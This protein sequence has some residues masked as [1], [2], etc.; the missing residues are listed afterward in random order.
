MEHEIDG[1]GIGLTLSK[2]LDEGMNG[3]IGFDRAPQQGTIFWVRLPRAETVDIEPSAEIDP[4][5]AS[6]DISCTVLYIEDNPASRELINMA[7]SEHP[8]LHLSMAGTGEQGIDIAKKT[9]PDLIL[10]DI[11]LPG[12]D[13]IATLK[14][15][16]SN[17]QLSNTHMVALSADAMPEQ[18]ETAMAAGF[19]LY[20]TKPVEPS[21]II[22]IIKEF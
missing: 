12:I 16:K 5:T 14:I 19:D 8:S 15:L 9:H 4:L 20:L 11:N 21:Q 1:T 10:I 3:S 18:I 6:A 22:K 17:P 2:F 13:G 7:L